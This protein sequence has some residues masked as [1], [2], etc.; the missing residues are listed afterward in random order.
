M[1]SP[2]ALVAGLVLAT[3]TLWAALVD[4]TM[5]AGVAM[6]RVIV[7][8][9][10]TTLA[11]TALQLLFGGF[12]RANEEKEKAKAAAKSTTSVLLSSDPTASEAAGSG[13]LRAPGGSAGRRGTD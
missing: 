2:A 1:I 7:I 12:A 3:P 10:G 11:W 5:P 13:E 9:I 8:L 4:G 6:Q